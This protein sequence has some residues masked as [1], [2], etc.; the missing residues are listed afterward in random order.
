MLQ[1]I[2]MPTA[3]AHSAD[4]PDRVYLASASG[5]VASVSVKDGTMQWR[6]HATAQGSVKLLRATSRGLFSVT[7]TGLVQAW[8]GTTG[9]LAWQREY[10]A[11]VADLILAGGAAKQTV[12]ILRESEL[13]AR[14]LAGKH[15]WSCQATE[16]GTSAQFWAVANRPDDGNLCVVAASAD[17]S[18]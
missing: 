11:T 7:D 14:T 2:G 6:R 17:G 13:E 15:E 1:Q 18:S 10:S 3:L 16:A 12:A 5:V 8:K 4:A 9:D